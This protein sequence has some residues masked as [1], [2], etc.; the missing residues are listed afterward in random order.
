[1]TS[2]PTLDLRALEALEAAFDQPSDNRI[3]WLEAE[4]VGD[5]AV[6][7]RVKEILADEDDPLPALRTG[8]ARDH[9][10]DDIQLE[11][12]GAYKISGLIGRGGMGAVYTAERETGDFEHSVAVKVI[13]AGVL[14]DALISRFENERQIL[15]S[16]NHPNI[17]R[18]FDGGRL[19]DGSPYI[20][21]EHVDGAPITEWLQSKD[22][23]IETRLSL[24]RTVCAA[25]EHAHQNLI[26]HRDITPSNVM[27]SKAGEVK[28]IDFGIAKP[29]ATSLVDDDPA[30]GSL[31]SLTVTPGFAA[32]ERAQGA[33]TN[34]LSDV[35]SLGKLLE[36][37]LGDVYTPNE[38]RAIIRRATMSAPKDRYSS[39]AALSLDIKN[40]Q[41]RE[42]VDAV[43]GGPIYRFSK[44]FRRR[45]LAITFSGLAALGLIAAFAV[46]L[47]QYLRAETALVSANERFEEAR[48]LSRTV[49]FDT[50][51][52]FSR[53]SGTLDARRK[54]ADLVTAYVDRLSQGQSVPNDVLYDIGLMNNRLSEVYGGIGL[55]N[56]GDTDQS[57]L[58]LE[59][60]ES[61]LDRLM[62]LEPGNTLALA[63]LVMVK[64]NLSMQDLIYRLDTDGALATNNEVLAL[65]SAGIEFSDENEQT[66]L[67]HFWSGRTDR[68]QILQEMGRSE[69]AAR[70]VGA[71]R[72]ELDEDMFKRL[73][74]GEEMAAYLAM[75]E[76]DLLI[77]LGRSTEA[78]EPLEYARSYRFSELTAQPDNY[79]QKTQLLTTYLVLSRA[80]TSLGDGQSALAASHQS[81]DLAR[82]I[83]NDDPEDMG[84]PEG[85]NSA[86]QSHAKRLYEQDR[87]AEA[88]EAASEAI[89]YARTLDQAFPD[90]P[91]YQR[92]LMNSLFTLAGVSGDRSGVCETLN[93]GRELLSSLKSGVNSGETLLDEPERLYSELSATQTCSKEN[94]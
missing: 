61:A 77:E 42:P 33:P 19:S 83:L 46:T 12:A 31:A 40:F 87:E 54:L 25:V 43:R 26:V 70:A 57:L 20:I 39:V 66:L 3:K 36:A 38:I 28:L 81:V 18:L 58:L 64:R 69:E 93:E 85:L 6:I 74:G 35:F 41:D 91:Y 67:R 71:W 82:E 88:L 32:P 84:G 47:V 15:A 51:D 34:T 30:P 37:M 9:L 10:D 8:G 75:Q 94:R 1:M 73:G 27:V 60:A 22:S 68:L 80:H 72:A 48:S 52:D 45:R 63:E 56:L 7:T 55:A 79:Y 2:D 11:R 53:V 62:E 89:I 76:A 13:R 59:R 29:H 90:D 5:P 16:L 4:Y 24:F 78:L 92:I 21:M 14:S 17:A 65:S 49:I 23:S 86:L 50:Y 44:F